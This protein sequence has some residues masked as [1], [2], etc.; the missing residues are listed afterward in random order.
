MILD[1]TEITKGDLDP[2]FVI[3]TNIGIER[4]WGVARLAPIVFRPKLPS[5]DFVKKAPTFPRSRHTIFDPELGLDRSV[6]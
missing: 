5:Y 6:G 3:P 2:F 4:K 1:G